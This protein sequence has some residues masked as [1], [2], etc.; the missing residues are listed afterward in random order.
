MGSEPMSYQANWELFTSV[1]VFDN[2]HL[3]LNTLQSFQLIFNS[4]F[5]YLSVPATPY[6]EEFVVSVVLGKDV[7]PR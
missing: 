7:V 2:V 3:I 1:L 4:R 6:C 5:L